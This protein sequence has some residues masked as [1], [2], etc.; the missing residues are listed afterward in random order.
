[1]IDDG[2][3][4]ASN[5]AGSAPGPLNVGFN[6]RTIGAWEAGTNKP[7][8]AD[9]AVRL[10]EKTGVRRAWWLGWADGTTS[11]DPSGLPISSG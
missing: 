11:P 6:D 9:V 5:G 8:L 2:S 1:V 4:S 7:D 3:D 10:E